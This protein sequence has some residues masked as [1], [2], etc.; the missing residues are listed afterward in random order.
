[1]KSKKVFVGLSGGVDSAVS[2]ALLQRDG[3]DVTGVFIKIWQPEFLECTWREDRL[4]AVRVAAHLK[5]PFREID[6]SDEYLREVVRDM[7]ADYQSGSTPNPDVLCNEKVKF[8]HFFSHARTHGADYVATGHYARVRHEGDG[9][10]LFRGCDPDKD[11]SY[12]LHRIGVDQLAHSLFPLG[13][14]K[15]SEVRKL[16]KTFALP[17]AE[18]SDSQGLCFVGA[19]SI[20]EFLA[21]Y[22]DLAEGAVLDTAGAKIG[23]HPGAALFT[24]GQRHGFSIEAGSERPMY[25]VRTDTNLNTITV[26]PERSD[27]DIECVAIH[28]LHWIRKP[29]ADEP[30]LV[31]TRYR[32]V[33]V[34]ARVTDDHIYFD[35]PH[36]VSVGQSAVLYSGDECMGGAV[37]KSA[38][39]AK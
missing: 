13:D 24:V 2:A 12:F 1:M 15:K 4:D 6:L 22:I 16:A 11:Q 29:E 8:G 17:V 26:S 25:V 14:L 38:T 23:S 3:Y 5:I 36:T 10:R 30:V 31:Q 21:R 7:I 33:P 27:A 9:A 19:V 39:G 35:Q 37:I 20:P 34:S 18:K 28:K 32:E